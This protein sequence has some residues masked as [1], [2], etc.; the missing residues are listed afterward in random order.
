MKI[1]WTFLYQPGQSVTLNVVYTPEL[2][3]E[4]LPH[5]GFLNPETNV[6]Y[7]D[8]DTFRRFNDYDVKGRRDAFQR[9]TRLV[10]GEE[11]KSPSGRVLTLTWPKTQPPEDEYDIS[12]R[13]L[14]IDPILLGFKDI[15]D[16]DH[17]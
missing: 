14:G 4:P 13:Y 15:T 2:D 8:W 1:S 9:L 7:V 11:A 10:K 5:G 17:L 3:A 16:Q 6:A 12:L